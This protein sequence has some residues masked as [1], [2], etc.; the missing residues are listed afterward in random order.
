MRN[1]KLAEYLFYGILFTI[2]VV[3]YGARV[4]L[5]G[6]Q[7]QEIDK[8]ENDNI[9]LQTEIDILNDTVQEYQSYQTSHLY[10]LYDVIPNDF[11]A[12][13]LTYKTVAMLES[14]GINE[15]DTYNRTVTVYPNY[16]S[17]AS[18][19]SEVAEGYYIVKVEVSFTTDDIND[20]VNFID[21]LYQSEQLFILDSL[22]YTDTGGDYQRE[23]NISFLAIYDL[24][25][26]QETSN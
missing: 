14:L 3:V 10:E 16:D 24:P 20:V 1:R 17:S 4:V 15:S 19:L 12:E 25:Q 5:V 6:G 9:S 18:V 2:T 7:Q 13:L 11:S 23:M 8:M 22:D 21:M 26:D